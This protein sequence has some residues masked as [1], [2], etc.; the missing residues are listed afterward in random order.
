MFFVQKKCLFSLFT[1]DKFSPLNSVVEFIL[2]SALQHVVP[3]YVSMYVFSGVF[4][5]FTPQS[6]AVTKH[7]ASAKQMRG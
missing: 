7:D 2:S 4:I 1:L 6:L 3:I 5:A